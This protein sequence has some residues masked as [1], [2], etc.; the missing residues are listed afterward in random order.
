MEEVI[1][2]ING[3][4][5]TA[6][7]AG[8]VG[9]ALAPVGHA[10]EIVEHVNAAGTF[11]TSRIDANGDTIASSWCTLQISGK[12]SS[13]SMQQC[14]NE[15]VLTGFTTECPGGVFEIDTANGVGA[16]TGVR[17]FSNGDQLF[18]ALTDRYLCAD[19]Q[20]NANGEDRGVILGGTGDY[21]GATG[22]YEYSYTGRIMY[23]DPVANPPQYFGAISSPSG[24]WV[25][26]LPDDE[27]EQ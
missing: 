27:D 6:I 18:L 12:A 19:D 10:K 7:A 16:G 25:I 15:D 5:V 3:P 20:G 4:R 13:Q 9:L 8:I 17:T 11:L 26:N 2:M 24:T 22:T 23:A 21:E 1:D 14:I